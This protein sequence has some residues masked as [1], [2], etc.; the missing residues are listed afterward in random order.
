METFRYLICALKVQ[1]VYTR[2]ILAES[3]FANF[4]PVEVEN[5]VELAEKLRF[6]EKSG[7]SSAGTNAV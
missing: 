2:E 7:F 1:S 4:G 5:W 6:D 3:N